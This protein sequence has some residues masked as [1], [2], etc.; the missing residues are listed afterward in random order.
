MNHDVKSWSCWKKHH[1]AV[2]VNVP[3]PHPDVQGRLTSVLWKWDMLEWKMKDVE[4]KDLHSDLAEGQHFFCWKASFC[5][6]CPARTELILPPSKK[7]TTLQAHFATAVRAPHH[8]NTVSQ[9][10]YS[11]NCTQTTTTITA[12]STFDTAA[13]TSVK[14]LDFSFFFFFFSLSILLLRYAANSALPSA[15]WNLQ[16]LNCLSFRM[17]GL[18]CVEICARQV[19]SSGLW[20]FKVMLMEKTR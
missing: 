4:I 6:V 11:E 15:I 12:I 20:C 7:S 10:L 13:S 14:L 9:V 16:R 19:E 3:H 17:L 18:G 5:T 8:K 2:R 1:H